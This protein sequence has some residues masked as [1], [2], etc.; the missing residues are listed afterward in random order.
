MRAHK[1]SPATKAPGV[2]P[3][4]ND[5][6]IQ[7]LNNRAKRDGYTG[8]THQYHCDAQYVESCVSNNFLEWLRLSDGSYA[9]EDG[10]DNR[11]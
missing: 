8:H 9:P 5:K 11:L 10:S 4:L 6:T 7:R 1:P 3:V 2:Y